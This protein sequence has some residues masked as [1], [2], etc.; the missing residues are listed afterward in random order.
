MRKFHYHI[1]HAGVCSKFSPQNS[2]PSGHLP[3]V[4]LT[5]KKNAD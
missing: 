5:E 2:F 1:F 3:D 4:R